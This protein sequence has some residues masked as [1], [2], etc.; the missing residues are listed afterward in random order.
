MARGNQRDLAR[1]KNLKKQQEA[2]KKKETGDP[3]K[4]ME[5]HA[6]IMR[7]KQAAS[8]ARKAAEALT[9]KK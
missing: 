3:A 1:A 6:E 4:R 2:N 9:G 5:T 8:D 7:Q